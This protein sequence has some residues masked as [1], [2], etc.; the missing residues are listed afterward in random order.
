MKAKGPSLLGCVNDGSNKLLVESEE[1]IAQQNEPPCVV[2]DS[3]NTVIN[4]VMC[5]VATELIADCDLAAN[6][7][8]F[9]L[10]MEV[11]DRPL[12]AALRTF[13]VANQGERLTERTLAARKLP[14]RL[15]D[16]AVRLMMPYL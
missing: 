15:R 12:A 14:E 7:L 6:R 5:I 13:V 3:L 16:A 4:R 9:E 11:Y 8:N 10:C 2:L 1:S